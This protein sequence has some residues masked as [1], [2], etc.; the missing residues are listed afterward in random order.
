MYIQ[1][2][3]GSFVVGPGERNKNRSEKAEEEIG[4]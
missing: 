2:I 3:L 1:A 4:V